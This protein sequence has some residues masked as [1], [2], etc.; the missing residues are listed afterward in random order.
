MALGWGSV[1]GKVFSWFPSSK[2]AKLNEID[3]L[4]RENENFQKGSLNTSD[5]AK[6]IFNANRIRRLRQELQ[7]IE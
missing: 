5:S 7:R 1:F 2:Q 4:L 6:Y 3:K